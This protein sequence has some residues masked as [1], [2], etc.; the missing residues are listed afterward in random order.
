MK[1]LSTT[2][3]WSS[4]WRDRKID[5]DKDYLQT[6]NHPHRNLIVRVLKTFNWGSLLEIGCGPGAN[7]V[8][9]VK[10]IPGR[11]V[12]GVDVNPEAI[13][14]AEKTFKGGLFKVSTGNDIM[15]SDKAT[16]VILS[17]MALIYV[18]P[19]KINSYIKE[20]KRVARTAVVLCEFHSTN[21]LKRMMIRFR[22]GYN[23]YDYVKLLENHGF[24]DIETYQLRPE[25]WPGIRNGDVRTLI[26]ARVPRR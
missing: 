10:N 8:N 18:G 24:Y 11:Q 12:G 21:W 26:V 17:D 6:W 20:I 22:D 2:K 3:T 4:W 7:L 15:I 25:D 9:I 19:T 16:D 13:A 5:W 14:L 1:L 23:C